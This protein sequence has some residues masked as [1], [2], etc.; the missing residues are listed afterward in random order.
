MGTYRL[1]QSNVEA[2]VE[3]FAQ[4]FVEKPPEID[5]LLEKID[6]QLKSAGG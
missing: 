2:A 5:V 6:A 4:E 1:T 3:V